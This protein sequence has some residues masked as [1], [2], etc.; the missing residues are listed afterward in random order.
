MARK[1]LVSTFAVLLVIGFL[2]ASLMT[3]APLKEVS[4]A[5]WHYYNCTV[6]QTDPVVMECEEVVQHDHS[7]S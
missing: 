1:I 6:I 2:S 4:A 3:I 5:K 7:S